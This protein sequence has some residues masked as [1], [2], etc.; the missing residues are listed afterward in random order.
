MAKYKKPKLT[1][2]QKVFIDEYLKCFNAAKAA[3]QAGYSEKSA[4]NIGWENVRKPEI[5]AEITARLDEVHMGSDEALKLLADMAR[6]DLG[7]FM[8]ISSVG[9]SLDLETAREE[10]KTKLIKKVSQKTIIDGKQDKETHIIDIELHDA[11]AALEKILRVHG[12]FKDPG[13]K[14][15]PLV[16]TWKEFISGSNSDPESDRK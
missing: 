11:Q 5:Q 2:K 3:R 12:K 8:A 15:N 10:G 4:Y 9:F 6:G 7:D 14:E 16:V 13:T 1:D